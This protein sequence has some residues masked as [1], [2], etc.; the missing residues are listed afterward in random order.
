MEIIQ[1]SL[2]FSCTVPFCNESLGVL[3]CVPQKAD[4]SEYLSSQLCI[5]LGQLVAFLLQPLLLMV[6]RL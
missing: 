2:L 5:S 1:T 6:M 4:F 3:P